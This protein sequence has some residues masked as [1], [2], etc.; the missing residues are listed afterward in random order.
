MPKS[1]IDPS[2]RVFSA[3]SKQENSTEKTKDKDSIFI[4]KKNKAALHPSK[5]QTNKKP[6]KWEVS[7]GNFSLL[8]ENVNV[9]HS[10]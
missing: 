10:F 2:F 7:I 1:F 8:L 4:L 5:N 3:V 6:N 9:F